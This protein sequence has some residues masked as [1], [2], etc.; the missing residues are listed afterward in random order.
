[1]EELLLIFGCET[2]LGVLDECEDMELV[3]R[4]EDFL[5]TGDRTGIM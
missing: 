2:D 4:N 1:M 5:D 3:T